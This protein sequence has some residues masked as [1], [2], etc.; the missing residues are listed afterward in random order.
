MSTLLALGL[1]LAGLCSSVHCLP[2]NMTPE[3][4]HKGASVDDHT[5]ASS[6]TDFAFSL[7]KQLALENPSRNVIFSPL[8]VSIALGFLSL[9]ARGSTLT[10]ILEGLKFNLTETRET[11]IH[12]GFQHLLQTLNRPSNELQLSVGNAMFV[13]EE[14]KL[15]DKFREDAR[16]LY[17]SQAFRTEFNDS[18]AAMKLI[19]DY[20]KNKTQGKVEDLFKD[21]DP[22]TKIILVNYIYFKAQWKTRFDPKHTQQAE[23]HVSENK[24]VE[25]PMMS[26]GGLETPYLRDEE[27][28]CTLVE[29]TYTSNDSALLILPDKGK[30]QDLEAK[31]NPETL[32]RWR[33]SL[34]PSLIDTLYLP[35]FSISSDYNLPHILS[36]L[37]IQKVFTAE[38]DLSG[39]T[40]V[41][42]LGVSQVVHSAVLDVD[43]EG[44]EGAAATGVE[45][46]PRS[47]FMTIVRFNRPFL[48]AIV[49]KD[50]QSIIFLG[51]VTN[52]SQA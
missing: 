21:L 36:K 52:P 42:D 3:K 9:G 16:A 10:E 33:E 18:N 19:N 40:D 41:M 32:T 20:V 15:L 17:A 49:L 48:I 43:E 14:L 28:G 30:M 12:Q 34:Q 22:L 1:F 39:I 25:V 8:S 5:L 38:A 13:Q 51:K 31:L 50:T 45:L 27:L 6:S 4:Q 46:S 37:G 35:K 47:A 23:F 11:E 29:L 7:Y 26:T 44:T 24:T 2:E